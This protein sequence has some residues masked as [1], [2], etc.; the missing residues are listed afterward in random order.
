MGAT[1]QRWVAQLASFDF[2]VKYRAGKEN[3]NADALSR[4]PV[5]V[6]P[7]TGAQSPTLAVNRVGVAASM[8]HDEMLECEDEDWGALQD[9]DG[10]SQPVKRYVESTYWPQ[11]LERKALPA[12]T[13]QLLHHCK[14]LCLQNGVLC[15][16]AVD[17]LHS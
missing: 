1:E 10:D 14:R 17:P 6:V 3:I 5:T 11:K 9:G 2:E 4:F 16:Q 7:S 13:Q 12:K 15:R 8:D